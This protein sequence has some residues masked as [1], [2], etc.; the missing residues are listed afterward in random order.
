MIKDRFQ[1]I[2]RRADLSEEEFEQDFLLQRKPVILTDIFK[3]QPI[4]S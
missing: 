3:Y 1:Q 4:Q 2:P